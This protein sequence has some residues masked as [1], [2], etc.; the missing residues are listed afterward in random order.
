V[1]SGILPMILPLPRRGGLLV[2]GL[3]AFAVHQAAY[4]LW[5]SKLDGLVW[6]LAQF[7]SIQT[8]VAVALLGR[9]RPSDGTSA[10]K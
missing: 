9:I 1:L 8:I 4:H 3:L 10:K 7:T 5:R 6:A 2:A